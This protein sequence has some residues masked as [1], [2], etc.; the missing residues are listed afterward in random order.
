MGNEQ[1]TT[2]LGMM[3]LLI[4]VLTF[5]FLSEKGCETDN[6]RAMIENAWLN[7]IMRGRRREHV[8]RSSRINPTK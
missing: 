2:Q 1:T 3:A 7:Q 4:G 6:R 5:L 8:F